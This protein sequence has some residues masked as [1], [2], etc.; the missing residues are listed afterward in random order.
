MHTYKYSEKEATSI[1][2]VMF[3][4]VKRTCN[5]QNQD[6]P[7]LYIRMHDDLEIKLVI[8]LLKN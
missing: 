3:N 8:K 4:I 2:L 6:K 7:K 5:L 1:K